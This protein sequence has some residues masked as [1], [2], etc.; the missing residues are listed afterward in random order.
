MKHPSEKIDQLLREILEKVAWGEPKKWNNY[1][2][3]QLSQLIF[4]KTEVL[5]SVVTLKRVFGKIKYDSNP[6]THTLNTLAQF[7]NYSDWRDFQLKQEKN[8]SKE[9]IAFPTQSQSKIQP[10]SPS[11][12]QT[13]FQPYLS[14][15]KYIKYVT[16]A[17]VGLIILGLFWRGF[18][19]SSDVYE[20]EDFSFEYLKIGE[21]IPAS[22]VFQYDASKAPVNS[23]IEIQQNWD[24]SRREEV[25]ATDS[26]HTII[27]YFPGFFDAKLV[28]D[29]KPVQE[30]SIFIP[31]N[32]W[33]TAIENEK[34]PIYVPLEHSK[35]K[36]VIG[37]EPDFLSTQGFHSQ[38]EGTWTNY[39]LVR[40]FD[41]FSDN[42][43]FEASLK[44]AALGGVNICQ[45]IETL[46]LFEGSAM[47]FPLAKK[48]CIAD[49]HLFIPNTQLDGKTENLSMFGVATE[50]WV[51]LKGVSKETRLSILLSND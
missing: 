33:I 10:Q 31:S 16:S 35:K 44:N 13:Q 21:G 8:T 25:Q 5:I 9:Y 24:K 29:D 40:E 39:N 1:D 45:K 50:D 26:I 48:G 3:E 41:I 38:S 34:T 32:G 6:S 37:I 49:L 28:V 23:K 4:D 22:V 20:S 2:F 12:A 19:S 11:K 27:Y 14:K 17:F 15:K 42:F 43:T 47:V 36:E 30:R 18:S 7:V 51:T 46:L